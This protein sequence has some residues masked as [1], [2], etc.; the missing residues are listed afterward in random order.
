[1]QNAEAGVRGTCQAGS[2]TPSF[3]APQAKSAGSAKLPGLRE[4]VWDGRRARSEALGVGKK[5]RQESKR[6][7]DVK[8][9]L[10]KRGV[11]VGW[12]SCFSRSQVGALG[13]PR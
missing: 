13:Q 12:E 3:L 8:S 9:P 7:R 11:E 10:R 1:M 6:K 5:G 4:E 2:P